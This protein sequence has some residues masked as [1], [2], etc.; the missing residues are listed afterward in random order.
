MGLGMD[1][2]GLHESEGVL[3]RRRNHALVVN[4]TAIYVSTMMSPLG[5]D[6]TCISSLIAII[7]TLR[8][9]VRHDGVVEVGYRLF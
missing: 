5:R 2:L 8:I 6:E 7:I 9:I 4:D 1:G 3:L